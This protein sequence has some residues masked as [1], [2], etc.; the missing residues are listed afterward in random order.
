[1]SV[2][3]KIA[4]L[5][6]ALAPFLLLYIAAPVAHAQQRERLPEWWGLY[7]EAQ[8]R[9]DAITTVMPEYPKK[10]IQQGITGVV[11]VKIA[12]DKQ[13][14]VAKIKIQP[15]VDP[16]LTKAVVNAVKQW[17]F[18]PQPDPKGSDRYHLSR[19]TFKFFITYGEGHVEMYTSPPGEERIG[20]RLNDADSA[21]E[22]SEWN[23]WEQ[24][25]ERSDDRPRE[26]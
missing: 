19:L 14:R 23:E 10:A 8:A 7:T 21:K 4:A 22:V 18:K 2:N 26:K 5:F 16:L 6:L 20:E 12:N 25:W 1:M 13:G 11:Q 3:R 9:W 15:R 24:V 17:M